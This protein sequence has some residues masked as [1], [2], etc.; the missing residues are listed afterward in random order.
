MDK[1]ERMLTGILAVT[2]VTNLLI[3]ILLGFALRYDLNSDAGTE[4]TPA[5]DLAVDCYTLVSAWYDTESDSATEDVAK[6]AVDERGC[7]P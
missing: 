6:Q 7:W 2:V 4:Q 5:V 3:L 1:I